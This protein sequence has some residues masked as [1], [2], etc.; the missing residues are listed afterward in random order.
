MAIRVA[1]SSLSSGKSTVICQVINSQRVV[2]PTREELQVEHD[3]H[4]CP[5]E[6]CCKVFKTSSQLQM[7]MT[8]HHQIQ[9]RKSTCTSANSGILSRDCVFYCPVEGCPR[10]KVNSQPFPRLGQL[11]QVCTSTVVYAGSQVTM[12]S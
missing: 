7:H 6:G 11:K 2:C 12:P 8:R 9:Q 10:S 3:E 5:S 1:A 4:V